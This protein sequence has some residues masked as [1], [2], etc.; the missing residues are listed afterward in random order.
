MAAYY[1]MNFR[2]QQKWKCNVVI[3]LTPLNF[4]LGIKKAG[5]EP[6]N[7]LMDDNVGN[8]QSISHL[9][10][11]HTDDLSYEPIFGKKVSILLIKSSKVGIVP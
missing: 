9:D 1:L 7:L 8:N 6:N 3:D 10:M 2:R 4:L 11:N 5:K